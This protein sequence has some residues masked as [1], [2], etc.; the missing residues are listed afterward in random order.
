[1]EIEPKVSRALVWPRKEIRSHG[2]V[3]FC[4]GLEECVSI[5][6]PWAWLD[7]VRFGFANKINPIVLRTGVSSSYFENA[8]TYNISLA[9]PTNHLARK[10]A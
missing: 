1:M 3:R 2:D 7:W 6:G 4:R 10:S 8:L 5:S 9:S